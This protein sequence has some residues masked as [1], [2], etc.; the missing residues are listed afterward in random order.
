M[1]RNAAYELR[2]RIEVL[3]SWHMQVVDWGLVWQSRAF[4]IGLAWHGMACESRMCVLQTQ[5]ATAYHRLSSLLAQ[6]FKVS[7]IEPFEK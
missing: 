3:G 7:P 1:Q 4:A 6:L 2:S 5:L